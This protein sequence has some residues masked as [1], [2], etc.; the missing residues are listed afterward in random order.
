MTAVPGG[1]KHKSLFDTGEF[2]KLIFEY[3][4][5]ENEV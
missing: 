5:A 2:L 4:L 1:I 3:T